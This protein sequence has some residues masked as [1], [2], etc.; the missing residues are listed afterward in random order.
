MH[1]SLSLQALLVNSSISTKDNEEPSAAVMV[2][3][4]DQAQDLPLKH[5]TREPNALVQVSLL[6]KTF[7]TRAIYNTVAPVWEDAFTFFVQNPQQQDLDIQVPV[8]LTK[9]LPLT[10]GLAPS[11][12][13]P[14]P[15]C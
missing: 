15:S 10:P 12:P 6:D 14:L 13:H 3:Y 8:L 9:C 1:L 5:G 7:E 2:V 4:V 11:L